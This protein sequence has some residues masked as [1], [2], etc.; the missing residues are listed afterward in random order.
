MDKILIELILTNQCNKRCE[1]C[2][3]DFQN[4][5]FSNENILNLDNFIKN[6]PAEY[7]IN[8]FWWEP[9]L[10]FEKLQKVV[11]TLWNKIKK[12]TIGTNG[13]MLNQ[14]Y[15]EYF[16]NN[17]IF[18]Y[19]SVDNISCWKDLN[20]EL[21]SKFAEI[22]QINFIN[23]PNFLFNSLSTFEKILDFW[24]QNIAF[25]PVFSTKKW[26]KSQLWELLKIYQTIKNIS[27]NIQL[28][29]YGYF[30]W[31]AIEKQ[32]ILDTDGNFYQDLDSLLWLQKQYSQLNPSLKEEIN[33]QTKL[34]NISELNI[35]LELLLKK[36]NIE[37]ILKLVFEIPKQSWHFMDYKIIDK[38]LENGTQKR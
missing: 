31:V 9:L 26:E 17:N 27:N 1:Y 38:I 16:K 12:F 37:E 34:L 2:D 4:T 36:Y 33:T 30:N 25:M 24:F 23:D 7:T 21:I 14:E 29:T 10:Q 35:S 6:N 8:F 20:L 19:L 22:I 15:L 28:N 11:K 18:I 13:V 5:V 32:F 3:L